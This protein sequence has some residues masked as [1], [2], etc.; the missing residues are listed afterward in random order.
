M[1]ARFAV[2]QLFLSTAEKTGW[3]ETDRQL[4]GQALRALD[5][6]R[7]AEGLPGMLKR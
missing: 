1:I 3:P 2:A 4:A 5:A 7:D 6:A